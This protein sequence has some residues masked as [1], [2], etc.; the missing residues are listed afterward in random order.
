MQLTFIRMIQIVA[1]L[2]TTWIGDKWWLHLTWGMAWRKGTKTEN[3]FQISRRYINFLFCFVCDAKMCWIHDGKNGVAGTD[4]SLDLC[5]VQIVSHE[6]MTCRI[7]FFKFKP[8]HHIIQNIAESQWL[9]TFLK[10]FS[11]S[12]NISWSVMSHVGTRE[13]VWYYD[14][15]M[16]QMNSGAWIPLIVH[17]MP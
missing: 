11:H 10:I 14:M 4:G 13:N 17:Y 8:F 6:G 2:K 5:K 3:I 1:P 16:W 15:Y 12:S 7:L 9:V